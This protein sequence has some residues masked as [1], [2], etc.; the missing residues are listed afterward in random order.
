MLIK[1]LILLVVLFFIYIAFFKKAAIKQEKKDKNKKISG[2]VMIEC[3]E[4]A[5]F[6]SEK[7][8]IIKDGKFFCSKECAKLR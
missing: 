1:A 5:T 3:S 4:C 2:D 7:E 8:A 6:V